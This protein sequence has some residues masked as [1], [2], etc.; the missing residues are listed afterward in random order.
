MKSNNQIAAGMSLVAMLA[1]CTVQLSTADA[2]SK[3]DNIR[4]FESGAGWLVYDEAVNVALHVMNPSKPKCHEVGEI[5]LLFET[6]DQ[7]RDDKLIEKAALTGMNHY[8]EFCR[9]HGAKPSRQQTVVGIIAGA[10]EPNK[11]GR[12]IGDGRLFEAMVSSLTGNYEVRIRRN[13]VAEGNSSAVT[14]IAAAAKKAPASGNAVAIGD[15][16]AKYDTMFKASSDN[17]PASGV[18]GGLTG[19]NRAKLTG[20]WSGSPKDCTK[21]RI[22]LFVKN[23][24][25]IIEWWRAPNEKIGLLPW[26]T[27]NWELR[28][29]TLTAS[30]DYH[31][32]YDRLRRKL[33]EG[34]IDETVQF[35]LKDVNSSD[36]RLAAIGGGFS[37]GKLFLG[38]AEKL[39]VR[40]HHLGPLPVDRGSSDIHRSQSLVA[41]GPKR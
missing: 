31:V 8:A 23:D 21:E 38:G 7:L 25:G 32:K 26:R 16:R 15:H 18:I 37:P 12:V 34:A 1:V 2:A 5:I 35:D 41:C 30:F 14:S 10:A 19:G 29:N 13:A 22:V 39:F 6:R 40:C 3:P 28:D 4:K 24:A 33:R 20:V 11:R 17:A 9:S 36:F 27:G